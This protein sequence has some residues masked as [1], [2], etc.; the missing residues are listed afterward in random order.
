MNEL[1]S[2]GYY[3]YQNKDLGFSL[4]LPKEFIYYQ[5]QRKQT[6]PAMDLE[7]LVPT[8]DMTYAQE[9][10]GYA[11]P[12]TVRIYNNQDWQNLPADNE[13]KKNFSLVN[14]RVDKIYLISFWD[15]VP[16]D[17]QDKWTEEMKQ[18]IEKSFRLD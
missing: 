10:P 2:D 12:V 14:D 13:D 17:W 1:S 9:V 6:G 4:A 8:S 5:T 11:K 16:T 15:K 7:I 18:N 3:H